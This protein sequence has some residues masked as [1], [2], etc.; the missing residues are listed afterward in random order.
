MALTVSI[1]EA[2]NSERCGLRDIE[3]RSISASVG[4]QRRGSID[5]NSFRKIGRRGPAVARIA[6]TDRGAQR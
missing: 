3:E 2:K 6:T 5:T 1:D 4:L